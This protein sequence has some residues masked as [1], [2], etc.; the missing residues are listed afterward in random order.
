[1]DEVPVRGDLAVIRRWFKSSASSGTGCCVETAFHPDEVLMRDSKYLRDPAD[2]PD[3]QPIISSS[4]A[5]W[6]AFVDAVRLHRYPAEGA[7]TATLD[8]DGWVTVRSSLDSS[9][10]LHFTPEEWDAFVTGVYEGEFAL[11]LVAP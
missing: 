11:A 4:H 6:T 10:E 3:L 9:V 1:M 2:D 5:D 7:L 8:A